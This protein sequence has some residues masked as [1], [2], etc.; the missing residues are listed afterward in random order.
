VNGAY[1]S[2]FPSTMPSPTLQPVPLEWAHLPPEITAQ[3]VAD[4]FPPPSVPKH[5]YLRLQPGA[6]CRYG[7]KDRARM[8]EIQT[9]SRRF[10]LDVRPLWLADVSLGDVDQRRAFLSQLQDEVRGHAALSI[11]CYVQT[12]SIVGTSTEIEDMDNLW[13]HVRLFCF[14]SRL[15][16][17]LNCQIRCCA[18]S[19]SSRICKRSSRRLSV[20]CSRLSQ[21]LRG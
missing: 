4:I 6:M 5:Q 1:P 2:C 18:H 20:R 21:T 13:Q 9:V 10:A 17:P 7:P 15:W 16:A 11:A 3:I 14:M 12:L 8:R 19:L